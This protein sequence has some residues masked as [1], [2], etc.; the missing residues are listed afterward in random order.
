MS[1]SVPLNP[2]KILHP[3]DLGFLSMTRQERLRALSQ[4]R[5][6]WSG[7]CC[8]WPFG[9]DTASLTCRS[10][11]C[12]G[13][14]LKSIRFP[15]QSVLLVCERNNA[16]LELGFLKLHGCFPLLVSGPEM[17]RYCYHRQAECTVQM[18]ALTWDLCDV[19]QT[20]TKVRRAVFTLWGLWWR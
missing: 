13:S 14:T 20:I 10:P 4:W 2:A 9:Q 17:W 7:G 3:P 12:G 5:G 6:S 18:L 19:G 15:L 8:T 11:W 16:F 1:I